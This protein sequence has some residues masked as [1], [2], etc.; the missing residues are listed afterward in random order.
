M[1]GANV[2]RLA[3]F[4]EAEQLTLAELLAE[5]EAEEAEDNSLEPGA[6]V[7]HVD[8]ADF[9]AV[10]VGPGRRPGQALV[11]VVSGWTCEPPACPVSVPRS[12][13]LEV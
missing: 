4:L 6:A 11:R 9:R 10:Y 3:A 2:G 5:I 12:K 8:F 1:T 13:L 7:G